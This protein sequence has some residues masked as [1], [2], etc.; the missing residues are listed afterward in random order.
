MFN[1]RE[2]YYKYEYVYVTK[3]M[4]EQMTIA[5]VIHLSVDRWGLG[6]DAFED[7]DFQ[8]CEPWDKDTVAIK[9]DTNNPFILALYHRCTV[10]ASENTWAPCSYMHNL[11][12]LF[13]S[14][15]GKNFLREVLELS[16]ELLSGTITKVLDHA[17]RS[18]GSEHEDKKIASDTEIEKFRELY[19]YRPNRTKSARS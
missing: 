14:D 16:N 19:A 6:I 2:R 10:V 3:E 13:K 17:L 18:L 4:V 11:E 5:D 12:D 1:D 7:K 9:V 15:N 8:T